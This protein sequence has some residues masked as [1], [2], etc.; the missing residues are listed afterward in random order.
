MPIR[1]WYA[2][3]LYLQ[4]FLALFASFMSVLFFALLIYKI[5]QTGLLLFVVFREG[6]GVGAYFLLFLILSL[7]A[8]PVFWGVLMLTTLRLSFWAALICY[9]SGL[10]VLLPL[11]PVIARSDITPMIGLLIYFGL[12]LTAGYGLVLLLY[13]EQNSKKGLSRT[14]YPGWEDYS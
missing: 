10:M 5:P 13:R 14:V 8:L 6:A 7:P 1:I 3:E 4:Y 9:L 11:I 12:A 2:G